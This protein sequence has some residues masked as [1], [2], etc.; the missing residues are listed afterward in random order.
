MIWEEALLYNGTSV[1]QFRGKPDLLIM[2]DGIQSAAKKPDEFL[3]MEVK[4][5]ITSHCLPLMEKKR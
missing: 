2:K 3:S 1:V 4:D 5:F